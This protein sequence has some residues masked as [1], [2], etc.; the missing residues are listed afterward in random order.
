MYHRLSTF[1]DA[2][3]IVVVLT[4]TLPSLSRDD[5][6]ARIQAVGGKVSAQV[7]KNTDYVVVGAS[8]GSKYDK[9]VSLGIPVLDEDRLL[10]LLS[11]AD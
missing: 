11:A 7:S 1:I 4:G 2:L 6:T 3:V 8:P 9:A 5:A 10:E